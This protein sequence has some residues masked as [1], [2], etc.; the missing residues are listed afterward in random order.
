MP[1]D[2]SSTVQTK[3]ALDTNV[4]VRLIT[5]D[6]E[7]QYKKA[8]KLLSRKNVTYVFDDVA[9][10]ELE[11]V[12]MKEPY[13]MSHE[14]IRMSMLKILN[15]DKISCNYELMAEALDIYVAHPALS[16]NDCFLAVKTA[17]EEAEPLWTFDHKL[18]VQSGT[19]KEVK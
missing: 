1:R 17:V 16:F 7:S 9:I 3:E 4:I 12:L 5:R 2:W 15:T 6:I 19:A 18:A 10:S 8:A 11:H 13:N 14:Q